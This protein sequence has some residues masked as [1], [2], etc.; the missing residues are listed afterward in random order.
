MAAVAA[1]AAAIIYAYQASELRKQNRHLAR[2]VEASNLLRLVLDLLGDK[3]AIAARKHILSLNKPDIAA[4][5]PTDR[6][7]GEEVIRSYDFLGLM[8]KRQL[9][10]EDLVLQMWGRRAIRL[11]KATAELLEELR[12]AA[13]DRTYMGNFSWL[14]LRAEEQQ[15][16]G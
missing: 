16:T 3:Q 4:W 7:L 13:G 12:S 10:P 14:A 11:H 2:S 8:A 5:T 6:E 1:C 15:R 9:I